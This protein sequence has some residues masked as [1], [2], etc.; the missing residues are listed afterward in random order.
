VDEHLDSEGFDRPE[1]EGEDLQIRVRSLFSDEFGT[2]LE[3]L[4]LGDI[5]TVLVPEDDV[6]IGNADRKILLR[7]GETHLL[8]QEEGDVVAEEEE[9]PLPVDEAVQGIGFPLEERLVEVV[10]IDYRR[11]DGKIPPGKEEAVDLGDDHPVLVRF[12]QVDPLRAL[13]ILVDG[14]FSCG[15]GFPPFLDTAVLYQIAGKMEIERLAA[16]SA[17]CVPKPRLRGI[18]TCVCPCFFS[19]KMA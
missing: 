6:R 10:K 18:F 5:L 11:L 17:A 4:V 12:F 7:K 9:I 3:K 16:E 15:H 2:R 19:G 14:P 8:C 13:G 1:Q